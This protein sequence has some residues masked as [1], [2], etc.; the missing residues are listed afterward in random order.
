MSSDPFMQLLGIEVLQVTPGQAH[1]RLT[2]QPSHLNLHGSVHGGLVYSLA[3]AAF[4][5]A[6]NS[7]G[8]NAVA[9]STAMQYFRPAQSG[10][11][12][13]AT[14]TEENLGRRTAAYRVLVSK[15]GKPVALFTGTVFREAS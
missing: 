11:V 13:E 1:L 10:D 12:L 6:S 3:D 7:H 4:T 9:L 8:I 2:I 5:L 14:A 15:G